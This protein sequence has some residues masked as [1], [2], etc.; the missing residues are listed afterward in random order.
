LKL[1][2]QRAQT[3]ANES[4]RQPLPVP[5]PLSIPPGSSPQMAAFLTFR[6]Q[7]IRE[8]ITFS[9]QYVTATP[10]VRHAAVV[11][12][13]QQNASRFQQVQALA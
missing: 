3:L 10:D 12:W 13:M 11:Q 7:L 5:P 2:A 8:Q 1:Q 6:D 9:N 4:A